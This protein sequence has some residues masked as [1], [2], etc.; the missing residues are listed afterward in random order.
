MRLVDGVC[1]RTGLQSNLKLRVSRCGKGFEREGAS[2][3]VDVSGCVISNDSAGSIFITNTFKLNSPSVSDIVGVKIVDTR[4]SYNQLT[5][6]SGSD[7]CVAIKRQSSV[8]VVVVIEGVSIYASN[9]FATKPQ[10]H[11]VRIVLEVLVS[12]AESEV[13]TDCGKVQ[14]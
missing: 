14:I 10:G 2:Y 8:V 3:A 5:C 12:C 13:K 11:F 7:D 6:V 1:R 4:N 9:F